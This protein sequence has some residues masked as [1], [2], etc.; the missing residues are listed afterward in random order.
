[1]P[2]A[3]STRI[4]LTSDLHYTLPHLDWVVRVAP[5]Y[6]LV[7]LAG[8]HLDISLR[9]PARWVWVYHWPPLGSPICCTGKRSYGDTELGGLIAQHRPDLVLTGHV[10]EP[11]FKPAGPGPTASATPGSSTPGARSA[12]CRRTSRST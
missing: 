7:V 8:D 11:P 9:R 2:P 12:Q 1:M 3:S 6:D 10:H 4:L 5:S